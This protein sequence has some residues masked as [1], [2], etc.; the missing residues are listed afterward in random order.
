MYPKKFETDG[1]SSL[2][3]I[4]GAYID[5]LTGRNAIQAYKDYQYFLAN[6]NAPRTFRKPVQPSNF[7]IQID[8][9]KIAPLG[10][11]ESWAEADIVSSVTTAIDY[12]SDNTDIRVFLKNGE[13]DLTA[14]WSPGVLNFGINKSEI[15]GT[16]HIVSIGVRDLPP[17]IR[18]E[19]CIL[20][21][22]VEL[23]TVIN[24]KNAEGATVREARRIIVP[25]KQEYK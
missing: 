20:Q 4:R 16:S 9:S 11:D 17:K 22:S 19:E 10:K 15:K 1:V 25:I 18:D 14:S 21:G 2:Y 5:V 8:L 12:Y 7:T 6:P 24:R 3:S 23:K 13:P